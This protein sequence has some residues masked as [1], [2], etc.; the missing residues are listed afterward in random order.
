M[1]CN[2]VGGYM[3]A[4]MVSSGRSR[5]RCLWDSSCAPDACHE[6]PDL[7]VLPWTLLGGLLLRKGFGRL[8]WAD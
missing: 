2:W 8:A 6:H 4:A 3:P 1:R 5:S 7:W